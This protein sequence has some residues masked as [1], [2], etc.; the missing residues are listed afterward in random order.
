MTA[1]QRN[2]R[3]KRR[4]RQENMVDKGNK[5]GGGGRYFAYE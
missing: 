1:R 4:I 5:K 3:C 2:R